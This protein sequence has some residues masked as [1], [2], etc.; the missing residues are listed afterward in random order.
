MDD[1]TGSHG[2]TYYWQG[3]NA[4]RLYKRFPDPYNNGEMTRVLVGAVWPTEHLIQTY[5]NIDASYKYYAVYWPPGVQR[6]QSFRYF[7]DLEEAK[8][9][10]IVLGRIG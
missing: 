9:W 1:G 7:N 2:V 10:V 8:A 5:S 3:N 6:S 4:Q